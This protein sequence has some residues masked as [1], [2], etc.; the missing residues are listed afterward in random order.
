LGRTLV[1]GRSAAYPWMSDGT[2]EGTK[3]AT[4][5]LRRFP[6]VPSSMV[7]FGDKVFASASIYYDSTVWVTTT[8]PDAPAYS[9]GIA[10]SSFTEMAGRVM[11]LSPKGLW[12]SDGTVAG[13]YAVVPDL[14]ERVVTNLAVMGGA[15]YFVT[16]SKKLWKSDGTF[17]GTVVVT[18]LS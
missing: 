15:L 12:S 9:L 6:N 18:T 4:G 8:A 1:F 11:F 7:A 17:E 13:S 10:G 16:E 3:V 2:P 14:G 5:F